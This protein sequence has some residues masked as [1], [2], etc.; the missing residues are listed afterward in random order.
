MS[1]SGLALRIR[2]K[3]KAGPFNHAGGGGGGVL[4]ACHPL[5]PLTPYIYSPSPIS[6]TTAAS[7]KIWNSVVALSTQVNFF[8]MQ[9]LDK[10]AHTQINIQ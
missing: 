3:V 9:L 5:Y 4:A 1:Q 10:A 7:K 6:F 8:K 2:S